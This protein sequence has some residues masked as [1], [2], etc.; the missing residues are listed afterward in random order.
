L[1]DST[2]TTHG[3]FAVLVLPYAFTASVTALLMPYLLRAHGAAVDEIAAIVAVANLPSIWSFLWS[4]V[5]DTGMSKRFWVAVSALGAGVTASAAVLAVDGSHSRLT[6]I[7]FVMN[8]FGGLLSSTCGALLTAVPE[9]SRG[10]AAGWYQ[11]ANTGASALGGALLIW[12]VDH[13]S[14]TMLAGMCLAGMALPAVA[15][16]RIAEPRVAQRAA[17]AFVR[18]LR[19]LLLASRTWIG[20][21]FLLSPVGSA[22]IGQIISGMGPDYG[23]SGTEVAWVTGVASGL[24]AA[25]GALIGGTVAARIGRM[26]SYPIAGALACLFAVYLGFAAATPLTYAV[27]YSGY[28]LA[29]GFAYAVYTAI[30]LDIIGRREH[31]AASSY[32]VLNSAGNLP[33]AYMT[34]FDGLAYRQGGVRGLTLADAGANGGFAALL[35]VVALAVRRRR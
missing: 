34:W 7:L 3:L 27:G 8:A 26:I 32:A 28:S 12:L 20:L 16:L 29:G 11:G 18:D 30:V 6:A 23:A 15:A 21:V 35:L 31:A 4:P 10:H 2:K 5:I 13:V 25:V 17:G 33:I 24:F 14:V 22:A 9:D 19:D 1:R